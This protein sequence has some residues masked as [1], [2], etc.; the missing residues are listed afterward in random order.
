MHLASY[1]ILQ[2]VRGAFSIGACIIPS[3]TA[4]FAAEKTL[5]RHGHMA[6]I[7]KSFMITDGGYPI[8]NA[9]HEH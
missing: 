6:R 2:V 3:I 8:T 4:S 1:F 5:D 7:R 9:N